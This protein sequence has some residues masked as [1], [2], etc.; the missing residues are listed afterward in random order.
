MNYVP[1]FL[2][3][4][5]IGENPEKYGFQR[6]RANSDYEPVSA[7]VPGGVTLAQISAKYAISETELTDLNP[8]LRRK[9]TPPGTTYEIWVPRG[10][11]QR[12]LAQGA[13]ELRPSIQES[14]YAREDGKN[15]NGGLKIPKYHKVKKSE[16][17]ASISQKYGLSQES[18]MKLNHLKSSRV[19][20]GKKLI[21]RTPLAA[22]KS[23]V[24]SSKSLASR[25]YRVK[26]GESLTMIAKKFGS[27]VQDLKKL[28]RLSKGNVYAGQNLLVSRM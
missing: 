13:D 8:H 7:R 18:I 6:A 21:L 19:K 3:A 12:R 24:S 25:T 28:N 17:L 20:V 22:S 14:D 5:L 15:G 26:R 27:T 4:M 16:T 11:G 1:K 9:A 23:K 10:E 2:A